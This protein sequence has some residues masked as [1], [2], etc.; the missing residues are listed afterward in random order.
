MPDPVRRP[1]WHRLASNEKAYVALSSENKIA[2]INVTTYR[3]E[4]RLHIG[5]Q[6]PRVIAV[7]DNRLHVIPFETSY[8]NSAHGLGMILRILLGF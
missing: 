7:R 5:A 3:V 4:K 8:K 1:R 6:A 2:V